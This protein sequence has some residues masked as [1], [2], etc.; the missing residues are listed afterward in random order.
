MKNGCAKGLGIRITKNV[1]SK[2]LATDAYMA[3]FNFAFNELRLHRIETS[4]F[5]DNLASLKFQEKLGCKRE[6]IKREAAFKNGE[7]K[8]IVTLGCLK[9]EFVPLY[10]A[11]IKSF[12]S[13]QGGVINSQFGCLLIYS[14]IMVSLPEQ[15]V[16]EFFDK[17]I[18]D[19]PSFREE[20]FKEKYARKLSANASFV[21]MRDM[22]DN[23]V[24]MIAAYL[25]NPPLCYIS[26][27]SVLDEY[28]RNG[29]FS[30]MLA[31]LEKIAKQE[32]CSFIELEVK[33]NNAPAIAA[34][35][36]NGFEFDSIASDDSVYMKKL[37]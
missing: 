33:E 32:N 12:N 28:K 22:N 19:F 17:T 1:Q 37:L 4:A 23:N 8:N 31:L 9:D 11:Y 34:Y 15:D 18:S 35:K 10:E 24:A 26:H 13:E 21:V 16:T 36:K 5:D 25:N 14:P 30:R 29:L 7:Y 6:G 2:G 27:V 3:M 20:E